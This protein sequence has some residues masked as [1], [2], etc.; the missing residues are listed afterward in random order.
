MGIVSMRMNV[1]LFEPSL[2]TLSISNTFYQSRYANY[3]FYF[4]VTDADCV[5]IEYGG[6]YPAHILMPDV[7]YSDSLNSVQVMRSVLNASMSA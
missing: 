2:R 5:P 6:S 7:Y 4:I 3:D 1:S